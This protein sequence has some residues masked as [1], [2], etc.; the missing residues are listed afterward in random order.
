M[1]YGSEHKHSFKEEIMFFKNKVVQFLFG[2]SFFCLVFFLSFSSVLAEVD[3][4]QALKDWREAE[5]LYK[6]WETE[7]RSEAAF[8]KS[9]DQFVEKWLAFK[10][11]F[12][13]F[14][15]NFTAR[16]GLNNNE[17]LTAFQ[18]IEKPLDVEQ[19][20]TTVYF[21]LQSVPEH[22][23][24]LLSWSLRTAQEKYR[25]WQRGKTNPPHPHKIELWLN[26]AETALQCFKIAE[27]LNPQGDYGENITIAEEAV[28]E[29]RV[30]FE[31]NLDAEEMKW[32]GNNPDW[33][34]EG[35]PDDLC[36][37]ALD[38]LKKNP[39]VRGDAYLDDPVEPLAVSLASSDW[40]VYKK[41]PLTHQP[42]Q[43][44]LDFYVAFAGKK[45]PRLAYR[46]LFTF[47]TKEEAGVKKEPP[48]YYANPHLYNHYKILKSN[49]TRQQAASSS[50]TTSGFSGL[51][52]RLFLSFSLIVG[53]LLA[54]A[55]F[56][57]EKIP[58]MSG[59]YARLDTQRGVV[60]IFMMIVGGLCFLRAFIFYFAPL[61]DILPILMAVVLG[62][63]LSFETLVGQQPK[64]TP[65]TPA[66]PE[67]ETATTDQKTT[68]KSR[69]FLVAN[70]EL[71]RKLEQNQLLLG[72]VAIALGLVH[73]VSG[74][75]WLF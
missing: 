1:F 3:Q 42:T 35:S 56:F 44:S 10:K 2:A 33:V 50:S 71:F 47:Y 21:S 57:R 22:S 27:K 36:E 19:D 64:T 20:F 30:A 11:R 29:A 70:K 45:E 14:W 23:K 75:S 32:P 55:T 43:Y 16:Y 73:L 37:A 66:G 17:V 54:A 31:K 28:K 49:V 8:N 5:S 24:Q 58:V 34:G 6:E 52:L 26:Q 48:F 59:F 7:L 25:E 62:L 51:V 69:E 74:G 13:P 12:D 63:I 67:T 72:F 65:S 15:E 60:G 4:K 53:G 38:F 40:S 9:P 18:D 41:A 68:C 39:A 61:T 46:Y